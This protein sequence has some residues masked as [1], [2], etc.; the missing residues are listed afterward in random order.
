MP[1]KQPAFKMKSKWFL[2]KHG[3]I[4]PFCFPFLKEKFIKR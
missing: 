4:I 1:N 3:I 2:C